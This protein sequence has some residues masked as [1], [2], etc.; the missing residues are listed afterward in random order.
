MAS[1][2]P[3][4]AELLERYHQRF[5][6]LDHELPEAAPRYGSWRR[7]PKGALARLGSQV[8]I[9]GV[10]L[11]ILAA[12]ASLSQL[13]IGRPEGSSDTTRP[14]LFDTPAGGAT[15]SVGPTS[16]YVAVGSWTAT[17]H[18]VPLADCQ[19]I[20]TVFVANLARTWQPIFEASGSQ[21]SVVARPDCPTVPDWADGWQCWQATASSPTGSVCMVI[22]RLD[23]PEASG[24]GQVGGDEMSGRFASP[25]LSFPDCE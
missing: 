18:E 6:A 9:S 4:D 7:Q 15:T 25:D 11:F 16:A 10:A 19:G 22:A 5:G 2:T 13:G 3:T 12:V 21:I 24:F 23:T 8:M 20:A 14:G 17:C 1:P